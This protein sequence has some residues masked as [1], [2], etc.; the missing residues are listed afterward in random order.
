MREP[1]VDFTSANEVIGYLTVNGIKQKSFQALS[2]IKPCRIIDCCYDYRE[3]QVQPWRVDPS[4]NG[5]LA[6]I[7]DF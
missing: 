4:Q 3:I 1:P 2:M 5:P 6:V 7:F